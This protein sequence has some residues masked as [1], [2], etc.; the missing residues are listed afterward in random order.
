MD[1]GARRLD[2]IGLKWELSHEMSQ[3]YAK[4]IAG[5]HDKDQRS[6]IYGMLYGISSN[7][8]SMQDLRDAYSATKDEYAR[9]WHSENRPYWLAN[10]LVRYDLQIQKWQQR[11]WQ[12]EET[13]RNFDSHKDLPTVE[14]LGLPAAN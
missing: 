8:G 7:N 6:E 1:L 10:V 3:N 14:S 4:A 5:E 9:V 13:I 12:F 11:G 2:L